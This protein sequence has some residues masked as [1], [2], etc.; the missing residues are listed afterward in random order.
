MTVVQGSSSIPQ[1]A[2]DPKTSRG[3]VGWGR[4]AVRGKFIVEPESGRTFWVKGVTYGPL[5]PADSSEEYGCT[6]QVN[7]DFAAIAASGFN[8]IR[9][10]TPPPTWLLNAAMQHGVRVMVGLAWEQHVTFLRDRRR[11]NEIEKRLREGVRHCAGHPA[12]L[13]YSVGNEIPASIARWYGPRA[14]ERWIER[15]YVAAKKEDARGLV[16]YVNYPST[17]YLNLPFLDLVC[18]NVYLERPG[19]L[20][21]YLARLQ[22]LAGE[23][24]LIL[25]EIGLDRLRNG[26]QAQARHVESQIRSA[27]A[28]GCAGSFVFSWT[29]QW[30]RGGL[31]IQDWQ[32]GLTDADRRPQPALEATRRALE[33]V[34]FG[35]N[36]HPPLVSVIVCTRNGAWRIR[37]CLENLGK[38]E[39]PAYEVVVVDDGSTDRT[40][41]IAGEYDVRVIRGIHRGLSAARNAGL[42]AARGEI[43]AYIDDDA[44]P[45]PHWLSY[46]AAGFEDG[47]R[48]GVGGPNLVPPDDGYVAQLVARAPGGP[49]HVLL[50]DQEAEHIPGCNMAFRRD[51][52]RE[53]GGFDEQFWIAGDDVDVCWRLMERGGTLGFAAS[54]VVWHRRR[55][56]VAAYWRQQVNYGRAEALLEAKW[57][58]KY[59]AMGHIVWRGRL[60]ASRDDR[61]KRVRYGT[62]G[63]ELFQP[64]E[65]PATVARLGVRSWPRLPEWYLALIVL[66]GMAVAGLIWHPLRWAAAASPV[67]LAL[68]VCRAWVDARRVLRRHRIGAIGSSIRGGLWD[69]C[70]LS[71]LHLIQP[72]ARLWGRISGG[73][74]PWRAPGIRGATRAC[75]PLGQEIALW[76]ESWR[77]LEQWLAEFEELMRREGSAPVRGGR[78]DRWDLEVRGG[79]LGGARALST[80]EEHGRGRQMLRLRLWPR[81][82]FDMVLAAAFLIGLV[83]VVAAW[84]GG[85]LTVGAVVAGAL[86]GAALVRALWE[87]GAAMKVMRGAADVLA[88][89]ICARADGKAAK[90]DTSSK[91][92]A[93]DEISRDS[94]DDDL[95]DDLDA[96]PIAER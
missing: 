30:Y 66:M 52:L 15:L 69:S 67:A 21:K 84:S 75:L 10:Y 43:V 8:T 83:A 60:Y 48:V 1:I 33:A 81:W 14:V 45:D 62:W 95:D 50:N 76:S 46:L 37:E 86:A 80:V 59:N 29:D 34:P 91:R 89:E 16:T 28:C 35:D 78:Y 96:L 90:A 44:Y 12:V 19:E 65:E 5:G 85:G 13:C 4:L 11:C 22:N 51:A 73:L 57:P 68:T 40:A 74:M 49:T 72:A 26:G 2:A 17:E 93:G 18:C 36:R 54:A 47:A 31:Q 9:T 41:E 7:R 58:Q 64:A 42:T 79:L 71:G 88:S 24:P 55:D 32:F 77:P 6:E 92:P 94:F 53:I 25:A 56:S 70:L 39:Y 38:L 3:P 23:R 27:F 20:E 61:R 63:S 87:A 82:S